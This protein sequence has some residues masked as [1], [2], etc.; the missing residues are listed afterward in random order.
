MLTP[1]ISA[2]PSHR[3]SAAQALLALAAEL[4]LVRLAGIEQREARQDDRVPVQLDVALVGSSTVLSHASG[5]YGNIARI[6]S[7]DFI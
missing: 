1:P 4:A 3:R 2:V 7:S 6:S 5:Q